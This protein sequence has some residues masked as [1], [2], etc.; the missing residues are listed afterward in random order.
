MSGECGPLP[1]ATVTIDDASE[2]GAWAEAMATLPSQA[3]AAAPVAT[4][5]KARIEA[6]LA[7]DPVVLGFAGSATIAAIVREVEAEA[8]WRVDRIAPDGL[9]DVIAW[10]QQRRDA[11][12][13]IAQVHAHDELGETARDRV[14]Q[15]DVQIVALLAGMHLG[16][17]AVRAEVAQT[18]VILTVTETL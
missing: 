15:L 16:A 7:A 13:T 12:E 4:G 8:Q 10:L 14:R 6:L 3:S 9:D 17:A 1:S 2:P 5:L 11:A 18:A